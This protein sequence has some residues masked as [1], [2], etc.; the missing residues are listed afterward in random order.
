MPRPP[1]PGASSVSPT[2]MPMTKNNTPMTTKLIDN[3]HFF[4]IAYSL[5]LGSTDSFRQQYLWV[6]RSLIPW[7]LYFGRTSTPICHISLQSA[8]QAA[9]P[10]NVFP[11][12]APTPSRSKCL[13]FLQSALLHS[14]K[15]N[16][17]KS[18]CSNIRVL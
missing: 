12:Y 1:A 6:L 9:N 2:Q 7:C 18:S 15:Y 4:I 17:P 5:Q 11:S 16:S 3:I 8:E 14:C 10:T 13:R